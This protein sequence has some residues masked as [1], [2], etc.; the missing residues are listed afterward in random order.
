MDIA[1]FFIETI[2]LSNAIQEVLCDLFDRLEK[3][4]VNIILMGY[5]GLE[6]F[7]NKRFREKFYIKKIQEYEDCIL[8]CSYENIEKY[9][10]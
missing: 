5:M 8:Y 4:N 3:N 1:V 2:E 10:K 9:S 6:Q 7:T